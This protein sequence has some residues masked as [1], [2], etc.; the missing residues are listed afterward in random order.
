MHRETEV[1]AEVVEV[2]VERGM[3]VHLVG[4]GEK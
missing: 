3:P 4:E 2:V 1:P